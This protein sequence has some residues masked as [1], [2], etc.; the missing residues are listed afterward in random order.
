[1]LDWL[2]SAQIRLIAAGLDVVSVQRQ[3]GH[4]SPA[5]T[6]RLYAGEF[7][8]AKRRDTIR[9]QIAASGLGAVLGISK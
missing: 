6:L 7:E 8:A 5:I 3:M 2:R 1:M 9:Q 4:A